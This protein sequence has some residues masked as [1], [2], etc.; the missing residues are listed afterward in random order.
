MEECTSGSFGTARV[1]G[2]S[3]FLLGVSG[4]GAIVKT[5]GNVRVSTLSWVIALQLE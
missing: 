4:S 5:K 2:W 1:A 3:A